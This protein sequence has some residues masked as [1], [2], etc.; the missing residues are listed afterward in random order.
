MFNFHVNA[1]LALTY[2]IILIIICQNMELQQNM[3]LK[4]TSSLHLRGSVPLS[5]NMDT[6]LESTGTKNTFN[7]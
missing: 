4:Q 5:V 6:R 1:T 2:I 7:G 3:A